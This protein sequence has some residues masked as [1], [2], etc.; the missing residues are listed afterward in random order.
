M[1]EKFNQKFNMKK[2][3][4]IVTLQSLYIIAFK[5]I[6][7]LQLFISTQRQNHTDYSDYNKIFLS[8]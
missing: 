3:D 2:I 1:F 4:Y 6:K 7:L 8:N 5:L